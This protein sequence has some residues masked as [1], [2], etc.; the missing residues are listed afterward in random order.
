MPLFI[1]AISI[2]D[3]VTVEYCIFTGHRLTLIPTLHLCTLLILGISLYLVA[4]TLLDHFTYT[5]NAHAL[6]C[7][8]GT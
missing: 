3:L 4:V 7:C 6:I 8:G 2:L 5:R 1:N